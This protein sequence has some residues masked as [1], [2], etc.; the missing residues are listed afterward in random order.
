[1]RF[2]FYLFK[3]GDLKN[4]LVELKES[5]NKLVEKEPI[6]EHFEH[7]LRSTF[8]CAGDISTLISELERC[9]ELLNELRSLKRKDLKMEQLEKLG[10]AK[11]ESLADYL[12]RSQR[13]EE[14]TTESENLLSALTDRFAAL[15]SAKLEVPE[16]YK[17]F[18]ELQKDIQEG[19]VIQKESVALNEEIMLITL[20]SSSSSRDR[21][22]QKLKNRMQLTV[23]GWSTLEDD[24]D[25]SI[26]LLQKESKRLQQS[27]L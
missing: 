5:V 6:I 13:N 15:K 19:L 21:I 2:F 16:L 3:I 7:Y 25:E 4:R 1:M 20:S 17:Q 26:A 9:D 8:P 27:M 12:A 10:N 11:R 14:K 18:I 24:I 22:F 23:A